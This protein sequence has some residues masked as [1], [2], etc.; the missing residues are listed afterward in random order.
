MRIVT[1]LRIM[2]I[3]AIVSSATLCLVGVKG[4]FSVN[5][6]IDYLAN[7]VLIK[8]DKAVNAD[9]DMYQVWVAQFSL[10][11]AIPGSQD[12]D[13]LIKDIEENLQQIAD[14]VEG[15]SKHA[16][17]EEEKSLV[18]E[19]KKGM[20]AWVGKVRNYISLLQENTPESRMKAEELLQNSKADFNRVRD[21]L[22]KMGEV[23]NTSQEVLSSARGH[24]NSTKWNLFTVTG[25]NTLLLLLFGA[26][27]A[28]SITRPIEK[29]IGGLEQVAQGD[30]TNDISYAGRDEIGRLAAASQK[31]ICQM[32]EL[33]KQIS[34]KAA[35]VSVSAQQLNFSSQQTAASASENAAIIGEIAST[36]EQVTS[37]IQGISAVSEAA[38]KHA[39]E[40]SD[41]ITRV[42]EQIQ[43]IA[44][45]AEEASNV[46]DV[47][48]KKSQEINQIVELI[49]GIADQTNLLAL[50]AAIEAARAGEQGRGFAV[51]AEEVRKL[52]EQS[53]SAAKDIYHLVNTIQS[54]S[55]KAVQGIAKGGKEVEA[56]IKVA[57]EVGVKFK[58]IIGAV[59]GLTSQIQEV[60]SASGQMSAGV[61]NV[62]ATTEEQTAAMEE[63]SA[64]AESLSNL[65]DE[66]NS[67]VGRFKI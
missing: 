35:V 4:I 28:R 46:I 40:G 42:N 13:S 31:M 11:H 6:Q 7:G 63:V 21:S 25:L 43:N 41:G 27:I 29:T 9:R 57:Q 65:A 45:A 5:G 50:N 59:Q 8:V 17:S 51:V 1:K 33:V 49:T 62:A 2:I 56:G 60:V 64:S 38:A 53:A 52:A 32:R 22:N 3:L 36:V 24:A 54:E 34:E 44:G 14:R 58:E 26:L 39:D 47:L 61:Q 67:L 10:W 15:Y 48:Y 23:A 37:N 18:V 12:W 16:F 66:L 19:Q 30:L 55:Q 20:E